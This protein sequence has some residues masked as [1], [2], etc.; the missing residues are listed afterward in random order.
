MNSYTT[1]DE[2]PTWLKPRIKQIRPNDWETWIN[3]PVPALQ[4]RSLLDVL[5][6]DDDGETVLRQYFTK[7]EGYFFD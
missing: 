7:V 2:L 5:N 1:F 3:K 4:D 6:N